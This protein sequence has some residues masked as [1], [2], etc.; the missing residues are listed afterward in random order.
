MNRRFDEDRAE[1]EAHFRERVRAYLELGESPEE[2][3]ASARRKFGDLEES[4]RAVRR[5]RVRARLR[6]ASTIL[7]QGA[8]WGLLWSVCLSALLMGLQG[9]LG[10]DDDVG[11]VGFALILGGVGFSAGVVFGALRRLCDRGRP[12]HAMPPARAALWGAVAAAVLPLVTLRADQT[13]WTAPFGALVA[14]ALCGVSRRLARRQTA[15]SG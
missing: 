11:S 8:L 9:L 4:L 13:L 2:A 15:R 14:W 5:H 10:P 7:G 6:S 1:M 12:L 3:E